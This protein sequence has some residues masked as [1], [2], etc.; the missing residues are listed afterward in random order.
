MRF[1][2]VSVDVWKVIFYS[3][4]CLVLA[5]VAWVF[6]KLV[7]ACFWLPGHLQREEIEM[8]DHLQQCDYDDTTD[9]TETQDD[10]LKKN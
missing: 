8:E 5:F 4:S 3:G 6:L 10:K 7:Y 9:E 2:K 1:Q